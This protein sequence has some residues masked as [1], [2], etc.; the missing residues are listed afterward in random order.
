MT[1]AVSRS[2]PGQG[3]TLTV[4]VGPNGKSFYHKR[5]VEEYVGRNLSA[6]D[7]FQGQIRLAKVQSAE[8]VQLARM[9]IKEVNKQGTQNHI[10]TDDDQLFALLSPAEKRLLGMYRF[11]VVTIRVEL[12]AE[13]HAKDWRD[14]LLCDFCA[15]SNHTG[16]HQRCLC[17]PGAASGSWR[18][19]NLVC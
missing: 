3:G 10:G 17:R 12:V 5:K 4:F 15:E 13:V 8:S 18:V 19:P 16:R 7:G 2:R 1:K 11:P 14:P 6:K 9:E